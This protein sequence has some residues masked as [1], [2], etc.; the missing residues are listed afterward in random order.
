MLVYME[1]WFSA[2]KIGDWATHLTENLN[3]RLNKM[4]SLKF[5]DSDLTFDYHPTETRADADPD[6]S[7]DT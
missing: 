7:L 6:N 4:I 5:R 3:L 1:I 2:G